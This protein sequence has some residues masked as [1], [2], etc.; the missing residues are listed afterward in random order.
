MA[1]EDHQDLRHSLDDAAE[2]LGT[3]VAADIPAL[4]L[5]PLERISSTTNTDDPPRLDDR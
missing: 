1:G 5:D 3:Q 2:K 4:P